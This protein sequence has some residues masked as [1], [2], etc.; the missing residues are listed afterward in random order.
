[1]F[2]ALRDSCSPS[3][4]LWLTVIH[5]QAVFKDQVHFN[6]HYP[7]SD[8]LPNTCNMSI[9]GPGL[10]GNVILL[11]F[12][13]ILQQSCQSTE[14]VKGL[15]TPL[16]PVIFDQAKHFSSPFTQFIQC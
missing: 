10:Q 15:Y 13:G 4:L 11:K 8:T 14:M 2:A 12:F 5:V 9:L 3:V 1:M 7:G 16:L 6:S